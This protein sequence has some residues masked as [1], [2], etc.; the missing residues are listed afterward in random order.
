MTE[1]RIA[2]ID[3]AA[4][5]ARAFFPSPTHW[6][7][8]VLYFLM[9]D[10]FSDAKETNVLDNDGFLV[11][12]PGGTP[13]F[14]P[15]DEGNAIGTPADALSWREAGSRFV[16]GTLLGLT[17]RLGYLR[18]LGITA[19]W[20]S[21]V[22][23]QVPTVES[24]HGYGVQNFLDV[25]PRFGNRDELRALVQTAHGMGIRVVLDVILNHSGDVFAYESQAARCDVFDSDGHLTHKE[26]CWQSDGSR[27]PVAGFRAAD[28]AATLP[29]GPVGTAH[30]PNGAIW[31]AEFQTA[32]TFTRKGRIR[33]FDFDP[34]FREGDFFD[35]KDIHLGTGSADEYRPS[36]ALRNLCDCLKF[37]IAFLDADGFRVDTVKH[38]DD[39]A[40]RFFTSVIHEFAEAIG[41]QNFYLV[42]EITG[43]RNNA[44]DT[45]ERIGMNAALGIEDIPDKLEYL[46]KGFRE[47]T[48]YFDLF[49]NSLQVGKE[50]HT[51][52]RDK[53]V[54]TLDDHDQVRKG[55]HKSRFANDEGPG[56]VDSRRG[57]LAVLALLTTSMGI[58]CIYYGTEQQFD[59]EGGNDRFIRE[60]MFGGAFGAFRSQGRHFFNEGSFVFVELSKILR[61]RR[62]EIAIRRGRQYLRPISG[63]GI[64]FGFPR[65]FGERLLSI[66]AWSRLFNQREVLLAI[67]TNFEASTSAWVTVDDGLHPVGRTLS[68]AYSSDAQQIGEQVT[69]EPRNGKA[70]QIR[71]P[72]AGF[73]VF[74]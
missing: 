28:G 22:F 23:K 13:M 30:F 52:F 17:A 41:K 62:Q 7:D 25:D 37:W 68:C 24:Y 16:G 27:Y 72:P 63:N 58:P 51:W 14:E 71:V 3:F 29:F 2:D 50:S 70:V 33:N 20:I 36:A 15:G 73:V 69:V 38:M 57:T 5:M 19:I 8:E 55:S 54:T 26:H 44:V 21:P 42:A 35:L 65:F 56:Q 67:N 32:E 39:G 46:V 10:R 53:V 61:L 47:P 1:S 43:G 34:E 45:L 4:L 18:R 64:D 60:A 59:G 31:P 49:R 40:S 9:L 48:S 11:T 6:E 74:R 12:R 66:V